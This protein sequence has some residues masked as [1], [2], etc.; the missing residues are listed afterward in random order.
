MRTAMWLSSA[1]IYAFLLG[2]PQQDSG[3]NPT[4]RT[5]DYS[6]AFV[7]SALEFMKKAG[8]YSFE[9]KNFTLRSPSIPQLGD[10]V[11]VAVFK[12]YDSTE[13]VEPKN[14]NA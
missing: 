9:A 2:V 14:A 5:D 8:G 12:I 7:K 10:G 13:L 4:V 6:I 1:L 11:S 3:I